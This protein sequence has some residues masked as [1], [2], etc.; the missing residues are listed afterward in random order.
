MTVR[1]RQ[2]W[3]EEW[4]GKDFRKQ[5]QNRAETVEKCQDDRDREL[6]ENCRIHCGIGNGRYPSE[7][8]KNLSLRIIFKK[9]SANGSDD[10]QPQTVLEARDVWFRY[11][12]GTPG[13]SARPEPGK[14]KRRT[15]LSARRQRKPE[16]STTLRLLGRIKSPTAAN[17]FKRK[18][19]GTYQ[20]ANMKKLLGILRR[21]RRVLSRI[22]SKKTCGDV[23]RTERLR[24]VIEKTEIRHLLGSHPYD[25][26]GGEQQRAALAKVLLFDPERSS[27]LDE[28][29]KGLDG[30]YK[31]KLAQILKGLTAEGRRRS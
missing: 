13:C 18:G 28:P 9:K 19:T 27:F 21:I 1:E 24:D 23:R 16:K 15:V 5:L 8:Q 22:R 17:F 14:Y 26:S 3:L 4:R 30:F 7:R 6:A 31:K 2:E 10:Q 20:R 12:K 11:E 29:T 25:L